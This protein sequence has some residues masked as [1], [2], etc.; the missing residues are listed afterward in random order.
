MIQSVSEKRL[1]QEW[2]DWYVMTGVKIKLAKYR[3]P[4]K[5]P[6]CGSRAIFAERKGGR[7]IQNCPDCDFNVIRL[8]RH[9]NGTIWEPGGDE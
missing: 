1:P 8:V 5:C 9:A 7:L 3:L 2:D 6:K 4:A